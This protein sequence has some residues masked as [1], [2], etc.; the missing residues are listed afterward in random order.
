[1]KLTRKN[2][3]LIFA[4]VLGAALG[5]YRANTGGFG[6]LIIT[7]VILAAYGVF[8]FLRGSSPAP[9]QDADSSG[10]SIFAYLSAGLLIVSAMLELKNIAGGKIS[11]FTACVLALGILSAVGMLLSTKDRNNETASL[12]CVVPVFFMSIFL[13]LI[14]KSYVAANPVISGYSTEIIAIMLLT[15]A[16]YGAASM[17][18]MNYSESITI[19]FSILGAAT[20]VTCVLVS[21]FMSLNTALLDLPELLA[22]ASILIYCIANFLFPPMKYVKPVSEAESSLSEPQKNPHLFD[23]DAQEPLP[24]LESIINEIK[25]EDIDYPEIDDIEIEDF[26][27]E[28]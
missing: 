28:E 11:V 18:F 25:G 19:T 16:A 8:A 17:R 6:L 26:E 2:S 20:F 10:Y 7:I 9:K 12:F 5:V 15:I 23:Q 13:L 27:I 1:M 14:Y 21:G 3:A 22:I 24:D 4:C